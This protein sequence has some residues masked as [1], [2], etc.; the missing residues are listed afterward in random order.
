MTSLRRRDMLIGAGAMLASPAILG[1]AQ[2][3]D[4]DVV[5]IG[6]GAAGLAATRRLLRDGATVV[7]IEAADRIG[8]RCVTDTSIFGVPYDL[9]AH[10]LHSAAQ[11]PFVDYGTDN[12]FDVYP[13]NEDEALYIGQRVASA[14]DV[15]DYDAALAATWRAIG[16]A[17]EAGRD[18]SVAEVAPDVG[19]WQDLVHLTIGPYSMAKD[20]DQFSCVDWYSGTGG[21][22]YYCREGFGALLAHSARDVPVRLDTR[23]DLVRWDGQGVT[24]ETD[25][26]TITAR[27]IIVTVSTGVLAAEGIRFDPALPDDMLEAIHGIPMGSYNRITLDFSEEPF[28]TDT[29]EYLAFQIPPS[30][31]LSPHGMGI[32]TNVSGTALTYCDAGGR[33]GADLFKEG[34]A[35]AID[36]AVS[37]LRQVFGPKIDRLFRTGHAITWDDNPLTLGSYA[38][39]DPGKAHLRAALRQPV[40]DRIWL[41]GEACHRSQWATVA[42][43]H[44]SG[45]EVADAVTEALRG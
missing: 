13:A 2:A 5:V 1:R 6:A 32:L 9:G 37:E 22:D 24:V 16:A 26:G 30:D 19:P 4:A 34:R 42:G 36:Y 41:A 18:V 40:G 10:W 27:A 45:Q 38:S 11:N 44:K 20:F 14:A 28:G 25:V 35:A 21:Q 33:F 3:T 15:A 29:D 43:A 8:G 7:T 39:A 31:G 17:A 12:G 23:A